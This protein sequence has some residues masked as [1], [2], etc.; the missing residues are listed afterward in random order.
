MSTNKEE[1][2][3]SLINFPEVYIQTSKEYED[4]NHCLRMLSLHPGLVY[5]YFIFLPAPCG[6]IPALTKPLLLFFHCAIVS[7]KASSGALNTK[8]LADNVA[9]I[10]ELW[11][12]KK[13]LTKNIV[14]WKSTCPLPDLFSA[15][16]SHL[17]ASDHQTAPKGTTSSRVA[18]DGSPEP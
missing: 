9:A 14:L 12:E 10:P 6:K 18:R 5:L 8:W 17:Y 2:A 11:S 4:V 1:K 7:V 16:L 3:I 13:N 15:Y